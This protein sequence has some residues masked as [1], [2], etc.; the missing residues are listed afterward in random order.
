MLSPKGVIRSL[1]YILYE[2]RLNNVQDKFESLETKYQK[3]QTEKDLLEKRHEKNCAEFRI[4]K[5]ESE[6]LS[7]EL[8][9]LSVALK[10]AKKQLKDET[11]KHEKIVSNHVA[12][13]QDGGSDFEHRFV[14]L[15]AKS[16]YTDGFYSEGVLFL[17]VQA[18]HM[19]HSIRQVKIVLRLPV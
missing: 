15:F 4:S 2:N 9:S 17:V 19:G 18:I 6:D 14:F 5:S 12:E 8:N 11:F 13:I 7:K 16:K 1:T 3:L 10:S